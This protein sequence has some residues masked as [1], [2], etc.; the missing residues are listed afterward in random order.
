MTKD[1]ALQATRRAFQRGKIRVSGSD[2]IGPGGQVLIRDL[3]R[4]DQ[5]RYAQGLTHPYY[6]A[7]VLLTGRPW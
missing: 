1:V 5:A 6:W 7:G 2:L 4:S 3:S